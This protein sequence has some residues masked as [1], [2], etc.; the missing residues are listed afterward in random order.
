MSFVPSA[1]ISFFHIPKNGGNTITSILKDSGLQLFNIGHTTYSEVYNNKASHNGS[2]PSNYKELILNSYKVAIVRNPYDRVRSNYCFYKKHPQSDYPIGN[3]SFE[4]FLIDVSEERRKHK[5]WFTQSQYIYHDGENKF[6]K[7]I[8]FDNFVSDMNDL[9]S[10]K[11]VDID[12]GSRHNLKTNSKTEIK[13]T[14][15]QKDFIYEFYKD[16]FINFGFEK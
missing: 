3:S 7:I 13:L 1:N 9:F 10:S 12:F 14:E 5:T 2:W 4:Q 11:G 16:D 6:D 15:K 8:K